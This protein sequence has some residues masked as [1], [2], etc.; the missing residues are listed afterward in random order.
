MRVHKNGTVPFANCWCVLLLAGALFLNSYP[1]AAKVQAHHLFL[2][3]IFFADFIY[4]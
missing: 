2:V 4:F 1:Q 3:A